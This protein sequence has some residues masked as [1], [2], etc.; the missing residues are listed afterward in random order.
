[1]R[2]QVKFD[3][4]DHYEPSSIADHCALYVIISDGSVVVDPFAS[5]VARAEG[6]EEVIVYA[7]IDLDH[8]QAIRSQIPITVQRRHDLYEVHQL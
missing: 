7:D 1:M 6:G 5:V 8:L 2:W 4:F 3:C